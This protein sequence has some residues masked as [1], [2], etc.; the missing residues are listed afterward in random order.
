MPTPSTVARTG[1][2]EHRT[3]AERGDEPGDDRRGGR[4]AID[5]RDEEQPPLA[6]LA[7]YEPQLAT[8][9]GRA[10][11]G[12][13]RSQPVGRLRAD[14]RRTGRQP[15]P[16]LGRHGIRGQ[17]DKDFTVWRLPPE[18]PCIV[19]VAHGGTNSVLLTHLLDVRPVPWEWLRF[20]SALAAYSVV[21][22][23]PLGMAG[24]VWSLQNFNEIDPQR[25][26]GLL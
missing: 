9:L 20:E 22:S 2:D 25:A 24:Y 15:R 16:K 18:P 23:R 3:L 11:K 17:R 14:Q 21:Q 26:A 8:S 13:G 7:R 1:G 12:A 10:L 5:G 4:R 6:G 19:I